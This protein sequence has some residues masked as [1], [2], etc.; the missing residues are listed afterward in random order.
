MKN[1]A[2]ERL[3]FMKYVPRGVRCISPFGPSRG[4]SP[5]FVRTNHNSFS[6]PA[7]QVSYKDVGS[8]FFPEE[9]V[10]TLFL[11]VDHIYRINM[12]QL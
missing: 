6:W 5:R 3:L 4:C 10:V 1:I 7:R 2:G 8:Q 9:F 11:A 12:E